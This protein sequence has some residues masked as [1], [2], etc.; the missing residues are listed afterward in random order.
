MNQ[1]KKEEKQMS[2]TEQFEK[3]ARCENHLALGLQ[4]D[5]KT[6]DSKVIIASNF[7]T[8][9]DLAL[10]LIKLFSQE[11]QMMAAFKKAYDFIYRLNK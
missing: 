10:M 8:E 5:E 1:E 2:K 9:D 3:I 11:P 6:D 7:E 4:K